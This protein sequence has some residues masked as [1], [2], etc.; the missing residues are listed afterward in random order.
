MHR[1]HFFLLLGLLVLTQPVPADAAEPELV[2]VQKI[3]DEGKHNAFTDLI[4][5]RDKWYCTFRE[6]DG[7]VGGDGQLRVLESADGLKWDSA[8]LVSERGI[9]LRDPKLSITP[10]DR[11]M[12]VA[13][14]SV[15]E[16]TNL[17]GR[18]PRVAFSKD[19]RKWTAPQRVLTEGEWLWR[20]TWH[21]G[22]AYGVSYNASE[23]TTAAAKEAAQ[24]GKVEPGPADWKL[25]LVA[26]RDG[27]DY[28]VI[29]H[30]DVPGHPNETTLRFL[31][32][33]EL[34]ALVRREGGNSFGWIGR[35]KA[36]Y[37][38]WSWKETRHRLGGPNF[39]RLPDGSLWAAGRTYP[40]GAKTAVAR[41]TAGGQYEPVLTLPSGGDTSYPGLV[42]REGRLWMSYYSS[43]EG[44]SAIY[45]AQ[46]KLPV[47]AAD[48]V[49]V[50]SGL[51]PG[52]PI[53]TI[54]E[55][56]NVTGPFAGELYCQVCEN[57]AN[58][59]A[60]IFA[61]DLSEPLVRL[62]KKIDAATA[63]NRD[64]EIG[65]FV[66]FLN[67]GEDLPPRL[68]DI[69]EKQALEKIV[70]TTYD[71]AGPDGFKV[72]SEADVTVVLYNDHLVKANHAFRKGELN[73]RAIEKILADLPK[74]LTN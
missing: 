60:M 69:A 23:R 50:Q 9:D 44:K 59:V 67:D 46:I 51:H 35:S 20:V 71:P 33:G 21:E 54:F 64:H 40:G 14:G 57:G 12:I 53:S 74:I 19:G 16:G 3:W 65:S 61:R 7:H 8:A 45:L 62:V 48:K 24:T 28:D 39:I 70:L 2:S 36:P 43:H 27:A 38:D 55:P 37:S 34:V 4:R 30:L 66:V 22:K 56:F 10:D 17:L 1:F 15:Y 47:E 63:A 41:M 73:D 72:N 29:T 52:E 68:R 6:A 26:S 13:G 58:P 32:D 11:L 42:W 18:Q 49:G 25:K 31:P 5:W